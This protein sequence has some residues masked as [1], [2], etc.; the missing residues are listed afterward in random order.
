MTDNHENAD[1]TK[2]SQPGNGHS[3]RRRHSRF[4]LAAIALVACGAVLGTL[5]TVAYDATAHVR[6]M[7]WGGGHGVTSIEEARDKALDRV[8]WLSGAIDATDEQA[9][10]LDAI[11]VRLAERI[12][13]LVEAHRANRRGFMEEMM[14][15]EI[16]REALQTLRSSEFALLDEGSSEIV[17]ALADAA[18]VM[19]PDQRRELG[20]FAKRMHKRFGH[21]GR[22]YGN[23]DEEKSSDAQ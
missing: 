17:D 1:T 9:V 6:K 8:A 23:H 21:H 15:P 18:N 2:E 5:A 14:R 16:D 22:A 10:A 3:K 11:A 4:G 19:T 20:L 12:Y 13:P 7:G